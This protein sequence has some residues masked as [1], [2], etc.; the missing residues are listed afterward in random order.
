[1]HRPMAHQLTITQDPSSQSNPAA[2]PVG[3]PGDRLRRI[4]NPGENVRSNISA[5]RT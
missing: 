4:I 5:A 2:Y 1:M 3:Q